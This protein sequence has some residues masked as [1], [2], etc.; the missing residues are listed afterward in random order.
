MKSHQQLV[1]TY[2][3]DENFWKKYQRKI[4][5]SSHLKC[6]FQRVVAADNFFKIESNCFAVIKACLVVTFLKKF[7][8]NLA[9]QKA[10]KFN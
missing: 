8:K 6:K 7:F 2:A 5:L 10:H 9:S 3:A 4:V 1:I